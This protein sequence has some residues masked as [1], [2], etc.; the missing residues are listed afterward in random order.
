MIKNIAKGAIVGVTELVPGISGSTIAMLLN[1]YERLIYSLSI[2][3]TS[4]RKQAYP[5][6][7]PFGI[8]LFLGA[9]SSMHLIN[10][11]LSE[12]RT[13]TLMFFMGIIVSYLPV[14]WKEPFKESPQKRRFRHYFLIMLFLSIVVFG[15][16]FTS[17]T[18]IDID[19]LTFSNYLFLF[20]SGF[21]ASTALVLPGISGALIL[22]ILGIYE[23]ALASLTSFHLPV[24]LP[25]ALG[26]VLGIVLSS[27][28]V[29]YLLAKFP[30]ET[31]SAV[32]GLVGSS[33]FVIL[34]EIDN[35]ITM[36]TTVMSIL[37]FSFGVLVVYQISYRNS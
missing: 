2:L 27:K 11:L 3:T 23:I 21:I 26:V 17:T 5:F 22:T 6:L 1:C 31:Y 32:I 15:Q 33:I 16:S 8:G 12:Y 14:L 9:I 34:S 28:I 7:I 37:T 10:Y 29:R 35:V 18:V 4:N 19:H 30:L 36:Q 20:I 13:P 24:I 25:I